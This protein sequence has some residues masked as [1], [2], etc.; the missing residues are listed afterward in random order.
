MNR[1]Q[2]NNNPCN[3][4]FAGQ[5]EATGPDDEHFA[6]FK[7]APAGFRAAHAQ[8]KLDQ[9]RGKTVGQFIAK[10]APPNE[11]NT[12][13]YLE[14]VCD[15]MACRTTDPLSDLSPYALAGVMAQEE[16]YYVKEA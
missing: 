16:G 12:S 5:V 10:Y 3:L 15:Q 7:D 1:S 4:R 9:E 13:Q 14:F 6:I 11:N 8:I 2:K